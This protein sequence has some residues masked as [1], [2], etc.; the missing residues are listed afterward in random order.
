MD[1]RQLKRFVTVA[2]VRS[3]NKAAEILCVSQPSLTRSIQL[4]E[5]SLDTKLLDRGPRGI[6]LTP[7]GED[8]LPHAKIILNERERAVASLNILRGQ[9]GETLSLGTDTVFATQRLPRALAAM[10][11]A[12][13]QIQ[14]KVVE[15]NFRA[16]LGLV[17]EGKVDMAFGSRAP[18]LDLTE[19]TFEPLAQEGASIVCRAQHPILANGPP[20]QADLAKARWIVSDEPLV[21]AGWAQM[22]TQWKQ[23]IPRVMIYTSSNQLVRQC[24]LH[25]DFL[26]ISDYTACAAEIEAGRL[27][28][29]E[30]HSGKYDRPTGMFRRSEG[31]LTR[32]AAAFIAILRT[33]CAEEAASRED[34][35]T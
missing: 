6:F 29:L 33:I 3:F 21:M 9:Q 23:P 11:D 28:R 25:G 13:P 35:A 18:Y 10:V 34:S 12:N 32:G 5:E 4:L 30:S 17:R 14:I 8:L 1:I 16:M 26:S 19:L 27:V 24:L 31:K 22:F 7:M 20:T 15:G 2:E